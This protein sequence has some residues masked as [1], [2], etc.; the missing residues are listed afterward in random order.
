MGEGGGEKKVRKNVRE[1]K[2]FGAEVWSS[3]G[4]AA[5]EKKLDGGDD[6]YNLE[7]RKLLTDVKHRAL[8]G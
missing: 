1:S 4:G 6:K 2:N 3:I 8:H 5:D 7:L